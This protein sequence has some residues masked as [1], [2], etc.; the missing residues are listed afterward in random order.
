MPQW[1]GWAAV[2]VVCGIA[3]ML[4]P[5]FFIGW[6]GVGA[7]VAAALSAFGAGPA[8]QVSSF[9]VASIA[10]VLSTKR[11]AGRWTK[12]SQQAKTNVYALEGKSAQVTVEIPEHG[13][14]Q[15]RVD[16]EVWT[17]TSEDGRRIPAGVTVKVVKVDGV[18]LVVTAGE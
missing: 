5:S 4:T 9:V 10:L 13:A 14:G 3:E 6:F 1:A 7:V 11:L 2:A 16:R 17:A 15:V 12:R 8:W 18:H